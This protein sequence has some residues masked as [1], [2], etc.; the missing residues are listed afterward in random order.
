M[1]QTARPAFKSIPPK[2]YITIYRLLFLIQEPTK[3]FNMKWYLAKIVFQ[4]VCGDG[5]HMA[6]FDEQL[7]LIAACNEDEAFEK[8]AGI[9]KNEEDNFFNLRQQ[10]V[11]WQ[12]VNVS[13][14]YYLSELIDGAEMYSR[15]NE[16]DDAEAYITSVHRR[17]ES[18]KRKHTHQ[19]LNLI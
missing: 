7:R 11:R 4:I 10:L 2:S 12:F 5:N 19:L 13:E 1:L 16:V 14:L 6:Q 18:I 8:A 15:I 3:L 17:A 9:G